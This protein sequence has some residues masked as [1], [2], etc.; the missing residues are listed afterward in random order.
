MPEKYKP[1]KLTPFRQTPGLCG[2]ASLKILLSYFEKNYSEK[3]LAQMSNAST[4][5]GTLHGGLIEA[6]KKLGAEVMAQDKGTIA[7]L[8]KYIYKEKLPVLI[9]WFDDTPPDP[10]DH[11]SVVYHIT[12]KFIYLMDPQLDSGKRK[13]SLK[14]FLELWYDYDIDE[15]KKIH[16]W[17]M[18]IK[19]FSPLNSRRA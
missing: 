1:L 13:M 18:V 3:K 9:G 16:R 12:E 10:W 8:K 15:T 5:I 14:K 2:P 7:E 11:F 17:Y 4:K 6:A 19:S